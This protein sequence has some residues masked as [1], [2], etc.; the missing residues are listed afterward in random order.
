M[1][2]ELT[3]LFYNLNLSLQVN[4]HF[5]PSC[6]DFCLSVHYH[7]L[8]YLSEQLHLWDLSIVHT[9]NVIVHQ[10]LSTV[11][12]LWVNTK[13]PQCCCIMFQ[14][15]QYSLKHV[16]FSESVNQIYVLKS[17]TSHLLMNKFEPTVTSDFN[18]HDSETI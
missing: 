7:H 2:K 13:H 8:L 10:M 1:L 15:F 16:R 3:Y 14:L 12:Q 18:K 4:L 5:L 9:P 17:I 6:L 11:Y